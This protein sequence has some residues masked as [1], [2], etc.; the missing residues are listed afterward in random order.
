[1]DG[2][3]KDQKEVSKIIN[4]MVNTNTKTKEIKKLEAY[5]Q[6]IPSKCMS[7][8][9][10]LAISREEAK[11]GAGLY[12]I[13]ELDL[14]NKHKKLWEVMHWGSEDLKEIAK[15]SKMEDVDQIEDILIELDVNDKLV[16]DNY[17]YK[18]VET[19]SFWYY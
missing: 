17:N 12:F 18:I 19:L 15:N 10:V 5:V 1:M 14:K 7:L 11:E 13:P 3:K 9:A 16:D 2:T 6:D 8:L 4:D